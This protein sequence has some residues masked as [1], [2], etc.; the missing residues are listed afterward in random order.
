M[1]FSISKDCVGCGSCARICP[2]GAASGEKKEMHWINAALCIEC[3]ACGRVC[4]K[5]AV[6]DGFGLVLDRIPQKEWPMPLFDF[7]VCVS[8]GVCIDTCPSNAIAQGL[9]KV[10]SKHLFPFVPD[11]SRCIAC[12]FC[13]QD[14]PVEA[15]VMAPCSSKLEETQAKAG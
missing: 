8:C 15:V 2:V 1:T 7:K 5:G 9:Q 10:G 4:P 14:C 12:G 11:P 13:A 3:G 6:L